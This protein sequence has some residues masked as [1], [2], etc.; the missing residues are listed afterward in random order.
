MGTL[1]H[2]VLRELLARDPAS[3]QVRPILLDI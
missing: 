2:T 1:G 3:P